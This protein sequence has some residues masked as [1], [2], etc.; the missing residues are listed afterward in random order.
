MSN[1]EFPYPTDVKHLT[2]TANLVCTMHV[3]C[4]IYDA[5]VNAF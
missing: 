4:K 3:I 1:C 5:N 2:D